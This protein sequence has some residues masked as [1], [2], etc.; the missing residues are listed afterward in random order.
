MQRNISY[1]IKCLECILFFYGFIS[2]D[3]VNNIPKKKKSL[4]ALRNKY[5]LKDNQNILYVDGNIL[6][7]I[8][9]KLYDEQRQKIRSFFPEIQEREIQEQKAQEKKE[10][11]RQEANAL[12]YEIVEKLQDQPGKT[13]RKHVIYSWLS[14][15]HEV[16]SKALEQ[17]SQFSLSKSGDTWYYAGEGK[18]AK[19]VAKK[20]EQQE[21]DA[22][23][24]ERL[25]HCGNVVRFDQAQNTPRQKVMARTH[26]AK[27]LSQKFQIPL[28]WIKDALGEQS[29]S[30]LQMP[31]GTFRYHGEAAEEVAHKV[32]DYARITTVDL[33]VWFDMTLS[34]VRQRLKKHA[35]SPSGKKQLEPGVYK[36][37]YYWRDIVLVFWQNEEEAPNTFEFLEYVQDEQTISLWRDRK[38][39]E[40]QRQKREKEEEQKKELLAHSQFADPKISLEA[41][42]YLHV[43]PTN[44]GKTYQAL[45]R[46]SKADKGCYLAPLRLL[47]WEVFEELNA[48]GCPCSLVTGEERVET[49]GARLTASTVEMFRPGSR[50]DCIVLD[51][52]QLC[53]DEHRGWAW[54]RAIL[55]ACTDELHIISSPPGQKLIGRILSSL[56]LSCEAIHYD[57]LTPL[58]TIDHPWTLDEMPP[59]TILVAF[60][61]IA[62]L[63]YKTLLENMG[64]SVSVIYGALPPE[65]RRKQA[66]R[67]LQGKTEICVATDAVGMGMNLPAQ[68]VCFAQTEKFDGQKQRKLTVNEVFQIAGRAGRYGIH[69]QGFVG[70]LEE[71]DLQFLK[72]CFAK[73]GINY[74]FARFEPLASEI[75]VLEG[76]LCN[77]LKDWAKLEVL[78]DQYKD[79]FRAGDLNQKMELAKDITIKNMR[80]LG[81]SKSL[82]LINSPVKNAQ[83]YWRSC[84]TQILR[85]KKLILPSTVKNP[86]SNRHGIQELETSI[87]ECEIY[88]WLSNRKE[89]AHLG[90]DREKVVRNKHKMSTKLDSLLLKKIDFMKRCSNCDR[91]LPVGYR[92][93]L[94]SKCFERQYFFK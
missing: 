52:T 77:R 82:V 69:D 43:G 50:Y 55:N 79:I 73:K 30:E 16:I 27:S 44:S 21:K 38:L 9:L 90:V 89:F 49:E 46:L 70:A 13:A 87:E 1:V 2:K 37:W 61:R 42:I 36:Y 86:K 10:R 60:S 15:N 72:T 32:F 78:P 34:Q 63:S 23:W 18:E 31:D 22:A 4:K 35:V 66:Q 56:G 25:V 62:V 54:T 65:V 41:K 91:I 8:P 6:E 80:N 57:R 14:K 24:E 19:R 94:C 81:I 7:S 39:K 33:A 67:F 88:L 64:R 26:T 53:A 29:V 12:V 76:S 83:D 20:L 51:E 3:A 17:I 28:S 48:K 59:Q 68:N 92:Y 74:T 85:D 75:E 47:A 71:N 45:Q 5:A 11:I 58:S 40:K 93:G 84:K